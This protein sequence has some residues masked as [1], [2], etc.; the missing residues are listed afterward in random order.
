MAKAYKAD[1][2]SLKDVT[3]DILLNVE[4]DDR[5]ELETAYMADLTEATE[6]YQLA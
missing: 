1:L 4:E 3:E 6:C 2:D 5:E